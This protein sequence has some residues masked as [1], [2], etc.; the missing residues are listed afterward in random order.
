M[1]A[2][3]IFAESAPKKKRKKEEPKDELKEEV[4]TL[5]PEEI[6]NVDVRFTL[7]TISIGTDMPKATDK[8][9]YPHNIFLISPQKH[10]LWVLIRSASARRF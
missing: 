1:T 9:G 10:M 8:R 3:E 2:A 4:K 7:I 5:K 6:E